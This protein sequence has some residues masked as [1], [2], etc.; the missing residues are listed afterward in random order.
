VLCCAVSVCSF[1][2]PIPESGTLTGFAGYFDSQLYGNVYLSIYPPTHSPGMFSWFPIYFPL[3]VRPPPP[4]LRLHITAHSHPH[5]T[6]R[7]A[8][9]NKLLQS[10]FQWSLL[11]DDVS[12]IVF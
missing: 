7:W 5:H 12:S 9:M 6:K 8:L 1:K 11:R 4:S 2:F 10:V 3:R